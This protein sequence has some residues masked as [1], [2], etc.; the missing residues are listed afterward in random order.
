MQQ[1]ERPDPRKRKRTPENVNDLAILNEL[2]FIPRKLTIRKNSYVGL[3]GLVNLGNTCFM[4]TIIQ[5]LCHTPTLRNFFLSKKYIG[6]CNHCEMVRYEG[7]RLRNHSQNNN[8]NLELDNKNDH[9]NQPTITI[10]GQKIRN[11][12]CDKCIVCEM[13]SICQN[14]YL[15]KTTPFCLDRLLYLVWTQAR[16]LAGYEQ[17]DAHEFLIALLDLLHQHL[18]PRSSTPTNRSLWEPPIT[19]IDRIFTGRLQS[20]VRCLKCGNISTTI[21]P[22]SDISL[23]LRKKMVSNG[24]N[25]VVNGNSTG[26]TNPN[27][28]GPSNSN[29]ISPTDTTHQ[30]KFTLE[31]CLIDFT[32]TE[33]LGTNCK[34]N[35]S[36]CKKPQL[37]SKQLSINRIPIVIC[38]HFKRFEQQSS[39]GRKISNFVEFG[40]EIDMRRFMSHNLSGRSTPVEE[41]RRQQNQQNQQNQKKSKSAEDDKNDKADDDEPNTQFENQ[42]N[43]NRFKYVLYA[44]VTHSGN[45][46]AGHYTCYIMH[47]SEWFYCDDHVIQMVSLSKVLKS[48]AY[49]LFYHKK[50]LDYE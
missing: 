6:L 16:H 40:A 32:K 12:Y 39:S 34:I 8:N 5:A 49:L 47:N 42:N 44:V 27:T 50:Y 18:A 45:L 29:T 19:M 11:T 3:R 9:Q 7:K 26:S 21:D 4:S 25:N 36:A 24:Q 38:L 28:P 10:N 13:A 33:N 43:E 22:F 14:F 2:N 31:E 1:N 37:S 15:G 48:E 46:Q 30:K 23:E 17:Q 35:C 41:E 20:D